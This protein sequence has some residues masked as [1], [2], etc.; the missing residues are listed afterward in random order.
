MTTALVVVDVQKDFCK[1][2]SLAVPGG[3]EIAY[4]I[5]NCM[6]LYGGGGSGRYEY[7]V[8]TKDFHIP[9]DSNG[10]HISDNP[11][12]VTTWP[13]HCIQGTDGALFHE[14]IGEVAEMFD[15]IFYKG[16]GSPAY[17]GFQAKR[18]ANLNRSIGGEYLL[19]WLREREVTHL[20]IVGIATDYCVK[21]TA[22][23][24]ILNGFQVRIPRQLTVAVG[25]P[26]Q[27]DLWIKTVYAAQGSSI[28]NIN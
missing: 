19:D 13:A 21:E 27:A 22:L 3:A 6:R 8:A 14:S 12:Y 23:D 9:A 11:D 24:G 18:W 7:M 26:A 2:G 15:A 1:G 4:R 25:G 16:Q 20:D 5:A 28:Y 17:S 10:G